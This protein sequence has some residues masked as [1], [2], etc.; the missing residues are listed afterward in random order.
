MLEE[1]VT[2]YFLINMP[3]TVFFLILIYTSGSNA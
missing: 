3:T 1:Y 2:A